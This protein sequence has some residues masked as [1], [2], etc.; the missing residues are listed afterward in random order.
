M[1]KK[2]DAPVIK[3]L[4]EDVKQYLKARFTLSKHDKPHQMIF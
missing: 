3:L 4:K 2:V 1:Q